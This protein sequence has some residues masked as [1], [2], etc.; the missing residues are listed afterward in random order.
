MCF[1]IK[2]KEDYYN[3]IHFIKSHVCFNVNRLW[4]IRNSLGDVTLRLLL[5][6]RLNCLA[7]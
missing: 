6:L 3:G 4:T 2:S 1:Y 5:R 7:K